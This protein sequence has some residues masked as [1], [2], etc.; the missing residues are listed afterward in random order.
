[1]EEQT[2]KTFTKNVSIVLALLVVFTFIIY[3]IAKDLGSKDESANNPSRITTT[4]D[5][6]KPVAGAYTG[7]AGAA[8][9]QEAVHPFQSL[10]QFAGV[11]L[12]LLARLGFRARFHRL[13][14][15]LRLA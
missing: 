7:E 11:D 8:A 1:M 2:D 5:R 3:F 14:L 9:I 12:G 6:I 13:G 4:G 10:G 15:V